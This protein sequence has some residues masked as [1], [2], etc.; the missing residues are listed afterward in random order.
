MQM[1]AFL[2]QS[3]QCV[4]QYKVNDASCAFSG[5]VSWTAEMRDCI[6]VEGNPFATACPH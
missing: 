3:V 1:L 6:E 5:E 2:K 4:A